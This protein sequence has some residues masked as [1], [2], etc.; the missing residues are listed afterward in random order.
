[1]E[2]IWVIWTVNETPDYRNNAYRQ[3]FHIIEAIADSRFYDE[4]AEIERDHPE[5]KVHV[6]RHHEPVPLDYLIYFRAK[7]MSRIVD[8]GIEDTRNYLQGAG[9]PFKGRAPTPVP[10]KPIGL[11][12]TEEMRGYW[13]RGEDDYQKGHDRGRERKSR[14]DFRLTIRADDLDRFLNEPEHAARAT[15][16]VECAELGGRFPV[17]DGEFN[18]FVKD[19]ASNAREMRYSLPFKNGDGEPYLLFGFKD[20]EDD[21]G[22]DL[23]ADT[24]TLFTRVHSGDTTDG[25]IVG[26]GMLR[27]RLQDLIKQMTTF[28]VHNAPNRTA[29]AKALARFGAFFFGELWDS[30]IRPVTL[31]GRG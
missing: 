24:T 19:A 21:P 9:I 4:L 25:P 23:W 3:H 26:A 13:S 28:R 31:L 16:Y 2:E 5:I 10:A 14:L 29:E 6:I 18:L 30:Y 1:A 17:E 20:V 27:L 8:L 22:F 12:F 15:G 11:E 7:A